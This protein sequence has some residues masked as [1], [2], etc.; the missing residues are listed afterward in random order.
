MLT[1]SASWPKMSPASTASPQRGH[2]PVRVTPRATTPRQPRPLS[3]RSACWATHSAT[4]IGMSVVLLDL[5]QG[6]LGEQPGRPDEHDED[7]DAEH[8]QVAELGGDVGGGERLAQADEQ[9]ADHGAGNAA[10]AAD[11][12]GGERLEPG[13]ES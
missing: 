12:G 8:D 5:L 1:F 3:A 13:E 7:E 11:D 6:G 10:D 2:Q 9:P 4:P